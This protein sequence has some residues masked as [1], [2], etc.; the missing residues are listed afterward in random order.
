MQV[1][2]KEREKPLELNCEILE[3][4]QQSDQKLRS[5]GLMPPFFL[6][7]DSLLLASGESGLDELSIVDSEKKDSLWALATPDK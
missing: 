6:I 1:H 5:T 3:A 4:I 7:L 2:E